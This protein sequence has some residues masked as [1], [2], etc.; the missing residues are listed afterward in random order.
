VRIPWRQDA[1]RADDVPMSADARTPGSSVRTCLWFDGRI[2][3]AAA[4]YVY[5]LPNSRIT[6]RSEYGQ[7]HESPGA[8]PSRDRP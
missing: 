7:A 8:R 1:A 3:E 2:D 4:F 5:P 6:G